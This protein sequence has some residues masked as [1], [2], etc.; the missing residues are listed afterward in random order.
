MSY[1]DETREVVLVVVMAL[2]GEPALAL[3]NSV[4]F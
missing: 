2:E 1:C 4:P 3:Q